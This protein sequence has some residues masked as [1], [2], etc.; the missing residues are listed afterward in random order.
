VERRAVTATIRSFKY[1]ERA[2]SSR[3]SAHRA[4]K[5]LVVK[6][7]DASNEATGICSAMSFQPL[8]PGDVDEPQEI[9]S[10]GVW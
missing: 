4:G 7:R 2:C 6:P 10:L 3:S 8:P 1:L 9:H 5:G